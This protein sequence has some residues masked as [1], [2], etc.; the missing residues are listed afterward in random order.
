[1]NKVTVGLEVHAQLLTQTKL[2]C[3]CKIDWQ[4]SQN[5]LVCPVCMGMPGTLPVLN[6]RAV[7]FAIKSALALNCSVN[8]TSIFSRKN[9]FY[10]DLPKGYQITQYDKPIAQNGFIMV[11]NRKIRI[12][13]VHLEE[14]AGK[15]IHTD[16]ETL[17]DFNRCGVPLIEIVTE[18]DIESSAEAVEYLMKLRQIL[19]YIGVCTGDMEKGNMRC[20]PNISVNRGNR[21]EIKN[22][23]SFKAVSKGID[24]EFERQTKA[25]DNNEEITHVTLLWDEKEEV[26]KPMRTK[27]SSEDYRYFPEPDLPP[28]VLKESWIEE[29]KATLPE[30]PET[31]ISRFVSQYGVPEQ[32][33]KI[34]CEEQ[35]MADYYESAVKVCNLPKQTANFIISDLL[36]V[37]NTLQTSLEKLTFSPAYTAELLS[38]IENGIITRKTAKDIL[39]ELIEKQESPAKFVEAKGLK[40]ISGGDEIE[41][42]VKKVLAEYPAEVERYKQ[43]K[44]QLF[45]FFTGKV[46]QETKG[47]ANPQSIKDLLLKNLG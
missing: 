25:I 14:D 39:P 27:E 22:L 36:A 29:I 30:L 8:T 18:P 45:A 47:K 20:E 38:L 42:A 26:T 34:L 6:K 28:L 35:V 23:N 16:K 3:G 2:F 19:R 13:R 9:Y 15:S 17:V 33:A 32:D 31:K 21:T 37:M 1:M 7:E 40:Q 46:M 41:N 44:V 11:N 24:Y 4:A 10:P 5:S 43:G 12:R